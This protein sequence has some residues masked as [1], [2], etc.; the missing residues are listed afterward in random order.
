VTLTEIND[1]ILDN[2]ELAIA[3][4]NQAPKLNSEYPDAYYAPVILRK[5]LL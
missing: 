3:D 5:E 2:V 4:F 1:A